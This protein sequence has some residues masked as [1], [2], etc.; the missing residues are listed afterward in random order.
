MANLFEGFGQWLQGMNIDPKH[1]ADQSLILADVILTPENGAEP[2]HY[3]G[4]SMFNIVKSDPKQRWA[5]IQDASYP[6]KKNREL[7]AFPHALAPSPHAGKKFV[8]RGDQ[9]DK[10][11][12]PRMPATPPGG[13][14]GGSPL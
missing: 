9:F 7:S 8:I 2:V 4:L 3:K 12:A 14:P 1:A 10:L 11:V 6:D 5:I 13:A